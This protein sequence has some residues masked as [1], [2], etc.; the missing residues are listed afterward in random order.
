MIAEAPTRRRGRMSATAADVPPAIQWHEGMLLAPQHFQWQSQRQESLLHY[1][2]STVSP[3]HWGVKHLRID[4]VLLMDGTFRVLELEAVLP[5]GLIVSHLP[6]EMP[7][8]VADLTQRAD[9][10]R[11]R[12][13]TVHLAVAARGRGVAL[14]DRFGFEDGGPAMDENTGEGDL[15][16][17]ILKPRLRLLLDDEPP[18]KYVTFPLAKVLY[19]NEV[20]TRT[21]YEPPWLRVAP[22]SAIYELC[23]GVAARLREKAAFLAEQA[24]SSMSSVRAPQL[25][26]TKSMVHAMVGGLPAFEAALRCGVSHPFPLYLTLCTLLGHVAGL[27]RALVPPVLEPYDHNDLFATFE[28][29][30][31]ALFQAV[32]EGVHEGYTAYAFSYEEGAFRLRFDPDW[33]NRPLILGVKAPLGVPETEMAAWIAA[34]LIAARPKIEDLWDRRVAGATRKRIESETDMVPIRGVSLYS[35]SADP[36]FV[37]PGEELEIRNLD[38]RE[39]K[40]RPDEVVLYVRNKT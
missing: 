5:D 39:G 29:V 31:I 24:R 13:L 25:L 7:D 38:D 20:F 22:G 27:G 26:E 19:R 4:P 30:R 37:T 3:F 1:H 10:L 34:S 14:A 18:P 8:L 2:A 17:P 35:L 28:Q 6:D 23:Q 33:M 16:L 15:P 21:S 9:D 40:R 36:E 11:Q 12:P 32:D